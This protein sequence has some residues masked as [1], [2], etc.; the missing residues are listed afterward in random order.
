VMTFAGLSRES[1]RAD[2][3]AFL[4]TLSDSTVPLPK[5]AANAPAPG[6]SGPAPAGQAP[7]GNTPAAPPPPAA[8]PKK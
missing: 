5:A 8:A 1:Q 4:D 2:V 3:I 6:G 7:A